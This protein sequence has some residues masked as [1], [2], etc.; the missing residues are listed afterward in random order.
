MKFWSRKLKRR[1]FKTCK[2]FNPTNYFGNKK[3]FP[4]VCLL[5]GP[6]LYVFHKYHEYSHRD[7]TLSKNSSFLTD[8]FK[9]Q[10]P[11][12]LLHITKYFVLPQKSRM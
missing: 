10:L 6:K 9:T 2:A 4:P 1:Y 11:C 12:I 3:I 5:F 8:F 7:L